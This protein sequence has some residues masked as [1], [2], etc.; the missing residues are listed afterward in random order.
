[1]RTVILEPVTAP[2]R[3]TRVLV[4]AGGGARRLGHDKLAADLGHGVTVLDALLAGVREALPLVPV[5]AVGP[6]RTTTQPVTWVR[7]DPPGGGPVAGLAAGL[8]GLDDGDVVAVLAGDQPFV[9]P[10]LPLLLTALGGA[11][12]AIGVDPSGADQP[13]TGCY[14]VG[15]L[16]RAIGSDPAGRSVRSLL[17]TLTVV[18]VSLTA[19]ASLD[20]DTAADLAQARDVADGPPAAPSLG[21]H[22]GDHDHH[23]RRPRG[24]APD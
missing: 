14:R 5:T 24:A 22:E 8:V 11:D 6:R 18:R 19:R 7:E 3:P 4:L 23:A 2:P 15:P 17:T 21:R 20:V 12:T 13:L 10:A 1:M 16:R 9:G